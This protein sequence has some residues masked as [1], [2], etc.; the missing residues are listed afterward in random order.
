VTIRFGIQHGAGD[1]NSVDERLE[2]I[3]DQVIARV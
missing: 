1:P 2:Q 3:A